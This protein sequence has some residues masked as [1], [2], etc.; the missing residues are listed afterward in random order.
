MPTPHGWILAVCGVVAV[1]IGRVFAIIELFVI[2]SGMVIAVAVAVAVVQLHRPHL[3]ITRWVHP[4][5]LTVGDT[6]RVDLLI[7]NRSRIR[8]PRIALTEPVGSDRTARMALAPL[9]RGGHV[10]AGYR[11][12]ALQRG[13]LQIGPTT[14]DRRDILGLAAEARE[15]TDVTQLTIAPLTFEMAM[16][17]LGHGVLG[18]HL[19]ALS[20]RIGPGEFHSLRDYVAGDEPRTVHWRASAR[21]EELKVRQHEAQGVRRCIIVLDRQLHG[22]SGDPTPA[23]REAFDR[24]ITA[25][26]SLVISAD[27]AGL[28]TRFVTGGGIDLRGP[29]VAAHTMRAL[30]PID[31]GVAL[32]EIDRDPGEGLG[33]LVVVTPSPASDAWRDVGRVGDPTL[34][35][36]GV[37]TMTPSPGHLSI[38]ATSIESFRRGWHRLAGARGL[39]SELHVTGEPA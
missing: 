19:L 25:A 14:V 11:V 1:V 2:G 38:D 37:F 26:G 35:K 13:V 24:A 5:M 30:G 3:S 22:A 15:A 18:R 27:R 39:V 6:G 31:A 10:T 8:S 28:T 9:A 29:E 23:D 20:R 33:L 32:G 12:P 36:V 16:P 4:P 34:T 7:E 17:S 21:S